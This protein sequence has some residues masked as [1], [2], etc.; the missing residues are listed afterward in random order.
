MLNCDQLKQISNKNKRKMWTKMPGFALEK[1]QNYWHLSLITVP[2][3]QKCWESYPSNLGRLLSKC[4]P[5]NLSVAIY[6]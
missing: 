5:P 4:E 2:Q 6:F 3:T 1:I